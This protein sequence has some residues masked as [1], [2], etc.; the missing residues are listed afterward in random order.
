MT[1]YVHLMHSIRAQIMR[2]LNAVEV[3]LLFKKDLQWKLK[4]SRR[5]HRLFSQRRCR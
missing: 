1:I 3:F 2:I 4:R 5:Y